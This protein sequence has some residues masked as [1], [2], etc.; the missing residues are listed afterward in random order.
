MQFSVLDLVNIVPVC[1]CSRSADAAHFQLR[2]PSP[3]S[4]A[5]PGTPGF[6]TLTDWTPAEEFSTEGKQNQHQHLSVKAICSNC[7]DFAYFRAKH[8]EIRRSETRTC[9]SVRQGSSHN[10]CF[11]LQKPELC[12]IQLFASRCINYLQQLQLYD[13]PPPPLMKIWLNQS[14]VNKAVNPGR[15]L[16]VLLLFY[17]NPKLCSYSC[18]CGK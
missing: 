17:Q 18:S 12:F 4:C 5:P 10:G 13:S 14:S 11:M 2:Q 16:K 15:A 9:T 8:D 1:L 6:S 3:F 7:V